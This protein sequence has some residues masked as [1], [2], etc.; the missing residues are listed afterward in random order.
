M[1]KKERHKEKRVWKEEMGKKTEG[2]E[3][4]TFGTTHQVYPNC[5]EYKF[6]P[7]TNSSFHPEHSYVQ[8]GL[9]VW[10]VQFRSIKCEV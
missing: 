1:K 7:E 6:A 9:I 8:V 10:E 3:E 5:K 2:E 4:R